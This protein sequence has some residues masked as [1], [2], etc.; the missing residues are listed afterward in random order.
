MYTWYRELQDAKDG[1]MLLYYTELP[2]SQAEER[3]SE[4]LK[5]EAAK[6]L[7]RLEEAT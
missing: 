4:H 1:S 5:E 6:V 7:A 3:F 2:R